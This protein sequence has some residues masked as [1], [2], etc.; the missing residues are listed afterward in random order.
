MERITPYQV[1]AL[2]YKEHIS[3]TANAGS[4]K[5]FVLSKRF[6]EIALN[7]NISLR[8][9]VA[10]TF[11]EKAAAELYKKISDEVEKR[12]NVSKADEEKEMLERIRRQLVSAN[13][14]TI[15][16][17]CIDI[18]KEFPA[19]AQI[20]ANFTPIDKSLSNELMQLSV[21]EIIRNSLNNP[22]EEK[23]IKYLIRL[24]GSKGLLASE[25]N[26][27][28]EKRKNILSLAES[29]Y[30]KDESEIA[31]FFHAKFSE[32][33]ETLF[34][35]KVKQL[36]V[37]IDEINSEVL[38]KDK[39]NEIALN[40]NHLLINLK[41]QNEFQ[42]GLK[43]IL[44][45][46]DLVLTEKGTVRQKGYL[47]KNRDDYKNQIA[48]VEEVLA[49]L[50]S[51]EIPDNHELVE[52]ELAKFG[53]I[54]VKVFTKTIDRYDEKKRLNGYLDFEDILIKTKN[55]LTQK[56]VCDQLFE[57]YKYIMVDEYQDTN[58]IQF[59]I[60][61]PILNY[62]GR[63]NLFVVGDEKQSIYMFRDA[64]LEIFRKT[65]ELISEAA[66]AE[67]LLVLPHS[68]RMAPNIC[69]FTN[70]LFAKLF[71]SP[72]KYFNEVEHGELVCSREGEEEGRIEFVIS[73]KDISVDSEAQL[74]AKRIKQLV[75]ES[76]NDNFSYDDF[77]ILC[78]RRKSFDELEETFTQLN[79]PYTIVGGKGFYQQQVIYDIYN[80]LAFLLNGKNDAALIG[81]LRSPFFLVSDSEIF[82]I[83]LEQKES[84]W[85]KLKSYSEKTNRLLNVIDI[86]NRNLDAAWNTEIPILVKKIIEET[87]YLA[88]IAG[89]PKGK[90]EI[91]SIEKLIRISNSFFNQG[92]KSLYDF[93]KFLEESTSTRIDEGEPGIS[94]LN[95]SVKI[96]TLHQS[97]GLE[98]KAVVL[99]NSHDYNTASV[100]KSKSIQTDKEF[101]ILTS[102]PLGNS[103]FSKYQN[104]PI[105]SL[106]NYFAR[107]KNQAE[108]KRLLYVGVTRAKDLLIISGEKKDS[109]FHKDSFLSLL[110]KGLD[111]D[112]SNEINLKSELQFLNYESTDYKFS[113]KNLEVKISVHF[114]IDLTEKE[115]TAEKNILPVQLKDKTT[116]ITD[117]QEEEIIS[118]TK[119]AVFNQCP[120]KYY[121]T[122]ELGYLDLFTNYKRSLID[123]DF[124]T[125]E[126]NEHRILAD[127]KGKIIHRILEK[128][129][130]LSDL[131]MY[132]DLLLSNEKEIQFQS[133]KTIDDLKSSII[134]SI[135][136]YYSSVNFGNLSE[137]KN[138]RNELEIYCRENDYF[139]YGIIDKL[140]IE[141]ESTTIID[142][143][144]DNIDA[145]EIRNRFNQYQ[146]QLL[147]YAYLVSRKYKQI[148]Q[149]K[150]QVIFL[151]Y[152]DVECILEL[153]RE[154]LKDIP[155]RIKDFV[156][157]VR[158]NKFEKNLNHCGKCVFSMNNGR[159]LKS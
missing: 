2:D 126:D 48:L 6:V 72:N 3:L 147:F 9:L 57:R 138:Y 158:N 29:L 145:D 36:A 67:K 37:Y 132:V 98:F 12:L 137:H 159:C 120:L 129:K 30:S 133:N 61:M 146:T 140:V 18:L 7:E 10:I 80:Y 154:E 100:V 155:I 84:L 69:L 33:S 109:P 116:A 58:E 49:E 104:A 75:T 143:K 27:L 123:Y 51:L 105:V 102:V 65:K 13:I 153:S 54:L 122:Y 148:Q 118:A 1:A 83:S 19:E 108:I 103:Y 90:Q 38:L 97:K 28:V 156:D 106:Y 86:L 142:F 4:G 53:K 101:G 25:L 34:K 94:L 32:T 56:E 64:E 135:R 8:N 99:Y 95:D 70:V 92:L 73:Q 62:L 21:E 134:E 131:G 157:K 26:D 76:N 44:A 110:E 91:A 112:I 88:V 150:L 66:S 115:L 127:V 125:S 41:K 114:E 93:V 79:I 63:G 23:E 136:Q 20:D 111:N 40:V 50:S 77:A 144:T 128:E 31:A 60:F 78:R 71:A 17:F 59:E 149:F 74:I 68:F 5:T 89:N 121:L 46:A 35:D 43:Q 47:S 139:L 107:K 52:R 14:S 81:I 39:S 22:E 87:G 16:S 96:M 82:E 117:N 124:Y 45:I 152:P 113:K 11:T 141:N 55:L 151:K 85:E 15:H 24:F 119:V 42:E 130:K